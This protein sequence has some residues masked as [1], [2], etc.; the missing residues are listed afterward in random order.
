MTDA[1]IKQAMKALATVTGL[2][3]TE[4][5]IER[6]LPAY[7]SYLAA[8]ATIQRVD[9]PIETEPM[10]IVVLPAERKS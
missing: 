10:P 1:D 8:M 9:L 4:E 7:Q 6:D 3:L 2:K 5:R